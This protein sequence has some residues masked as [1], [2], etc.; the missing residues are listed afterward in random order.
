M[1]A[2]TEQGLLLL[3][4]VERRYKRRGHRVLLRPRGAD[5]PLFLSRFEPDM[6]AYKDQESVVIEVKSRAELAA[7]KYLVDLASAVN[8][9]QGWRFDLAVINP[10]MP[11]LV[12][13]DVENLGE[14]E[15]IARMRAI[16]Q[17]TKE[18][19]DEAAILLAWSTVEAALRLIA[20]QQ[21]IVLE[22]DQPAFVIKKLYSLGVLGQEDYEVLSK[23]LRARNIIA[24]G[25]RLPEPEPR[26]AETLIRNIDLMLRMPSQSIPPD[27]EQMSAIR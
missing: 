18:R 17:L 4:T 14:T 15:I 24:H 5:L 9:E 8:V 16:R 2:A 12:D 21:N 25:F 11:P 26:L 20:E 7:S 6:I 10:E 22:D 19:Q 3:Q 27:A 23:G 13:E 1:S